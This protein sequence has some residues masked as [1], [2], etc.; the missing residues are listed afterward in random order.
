[1]E[2]AS[3]INISPV[4]VEKCVKDIVIKDKGLFITN[5]DKDDFDFSRV[6][7][8]NMIRRGNELIDLP[9]GVSVFKAEFGRIRGQGSSFKDINFFYTGDALLPLGTHIFK[10]PSVFKAYKLD[11]NNNIT[12]EPLGDFLIDRLDKQVILT[13]T[14]SKKEASKYMKGHEKLGS[15]Y[16]PFWEDAIILQFIIL[17]MKVKEKDMKRQL[18][19]L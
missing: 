12:S 16:P 14:L 9:N 17:Q 2:N 6:G 3:E 1:M 19:L 4:S 5:Y 7:Q 11:S 8:S 10:N 15:S 13:R 18:N